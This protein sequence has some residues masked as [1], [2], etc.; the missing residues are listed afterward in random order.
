MEYYSAL[1]RGGGESVSHVIAWVNPKN[2][3]LNE[4]SQPPKDKYCIT[5]V[6]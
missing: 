5:T 6:I 3:M 1:K 4:I 2:V